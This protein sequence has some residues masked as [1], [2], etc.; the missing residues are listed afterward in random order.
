MCM[1]ERHDKAIAGMSRSS[2]TSKGLMQAQSDAGRKKLWELQAPEA[3]RK[4]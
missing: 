1:R 4:G 3:L 2:M